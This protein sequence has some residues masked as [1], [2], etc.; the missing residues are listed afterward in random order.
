MSPTFSALSVRNYRLFFTGMLA[1]NTGTW[2]QRV[3][4][5][6]LVLTLTGGSGA[7]LGVTMGL[8]FAPYLLFSLWGGKLADRMRRRSLLMVTQG[9]MGLL[10]V[11]L[12]TLTLT[13][14]ITITML[15]A[16]S[17]ALGIISALDAPARQA[18]VAELVGRDRL[19]NAVALNSASFNLGRVGGPAIA[20]VLIAA[21]GT[22]WVFLING[23]SFGAAIVALALIRMAELASPATRGKKGEVRLRDG[24]TYLRG[25]ADLMLVLAVVAAVGTFGFN[26]PLTLAMMARVEF[27]GTAAS[28]GLLSTSIAVGS[29]AGSL[30]AARRG[31]PPLALVASAAIGFSILE[32]GAALM[33]SVVTL[34]LWMPLVGFAA[35]T[36][37]TAAQ[38]YV[39]LHCAP[40]MRGRVMGVYL[41]LFFGGTPFGAPLL[42]WIA[43]TAGPRWTLGL[44]GL[45]VLVV[46]AISALVMRT[47][48][49]EAGRVA[50]ASHRRVEAAEAADA[51]GA[52]DAGADRSVRSKA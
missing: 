3:A 24:I 8:Q 12:A 1:S 39:Q 22:G 48:A 34:A 27:G 29:L 46:V 10:A 4:Q 2:M 38:S 17:L 42:G 16:L 49:G 41:L 7:A 9:A 50:D 47:R 51:A 40:E 20:G 32:M 30:L 52:I 14:S 11:V 33:P 45:A 36:F 15:Y 19:T 6:W 26:F 37:S 18:F 35:L 31:A 21:I 44:G 43:D 5:D 28:L 23:V 13:G 25:R